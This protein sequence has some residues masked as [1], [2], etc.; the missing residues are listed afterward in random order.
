MGIENAVG[1]LVAA[2]LVSVMLLSFAL[3]AKVFAQAGSIG[4]TVGKTDKSQS[5]V[6]EEPSFR[7]EPRARKP[8]K[9]AGAPRGTEASSCSRMPG[10][11]SWFNGGSVVIRPGGTATGGGLTATWS[12]KNDFVVMHWSHGYTDRLTLSRDGSHLEGTN[13]IIAVTGDRR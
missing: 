12:C 13:G 7:P 1:R 8:A 10:T 5:G 4:G 11:W 6:H 3:T 9:Q 2:A